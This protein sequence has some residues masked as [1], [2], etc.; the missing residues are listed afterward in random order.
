MSPKAENH[1]AKLQIEISLKQFLLLK[2]LK[3]IE[4][5]ESKLKRVRSACF[6]VQLMLK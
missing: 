3:G 4:K 1:I 6:P 5:I 2:I